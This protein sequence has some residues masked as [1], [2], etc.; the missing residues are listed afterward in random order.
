MDEAL[1]LGVDALYLFTPDKMSFYG[2]LGW[3]VLEQMQ[4]RGTDV[5]VMVYEFE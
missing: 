2:R 1:A 4:H 3:Q 5:T